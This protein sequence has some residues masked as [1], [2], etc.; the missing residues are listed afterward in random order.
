M[1]VQWYLRFRLSYAAMDE[2]LAER[3]VAVDPSTIHDRMR[4]F[5]PQYEADARPFR[6]AV[7]S[8]RSVDEAD[9]KVAGKPTYVYRAIDGRG[10][11]IDVDVRQRRA[12]ADATAFFRRAVEATGLIPDEMTI[13]GA[14]AYPPALAAAPPPVLQA[15][16][17]RV[18]PRVERD[19][20]LYWPF[21]LS[22]MISRQSKCK[23]ARTSGWMD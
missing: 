8:I 1:A 22:A 23:S 9:T 14:A 19:H 21:T 12:T 13:D 3:G 16:G 7:G 20:Q 18:Q 2:L 17:K 4:E 15:T 6:R 11:G 5:A 10:Q